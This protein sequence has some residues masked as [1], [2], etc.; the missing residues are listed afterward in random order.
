MRNRVIP[1][2]FSIEPDLLEDAK[3]LAKLRGY[4][5]S[6]SA[7]ITDIIRK[8]ISCLQNEKHQQVQSNRLR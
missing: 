5:Y 1:H 8:E 4:R 2:S 6:F 7:W 3:R